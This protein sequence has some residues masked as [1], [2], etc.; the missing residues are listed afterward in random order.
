[1]VSFTS[2]FIVF[3]ASRGKNS[4]DTLQI[5]LS[6]VLVQ[7]CKAY[8]SKLGRPQHEPREPTHV[9]VNGGIAALIG[10]YCFRSFDV[11]DELGSGGGTRTPDPRIMIPVL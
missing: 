7:V 8:I 2:S 5:Q 11:A 3:D 10:V 6:C 4:A 1:M 9:K